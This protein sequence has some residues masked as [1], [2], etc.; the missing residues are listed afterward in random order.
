[1]WVS[2]DYFPTE[3]CIAV[4]RQMRNSLAEARLVHK[5][6]N[7]LGAIQIYLDHIAKIDMKR[8]TD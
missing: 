8:L 7:G 5:T 4:C 2:K 1:M 6:G 3:D